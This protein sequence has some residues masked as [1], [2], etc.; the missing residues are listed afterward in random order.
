M[1]VA[2]FHDAR[3]KKYQKTVYTSGGLT[4]TYLQRYL[5]F[6]SK[7]T[8]C[9]REEVVK[10]EEEIKKLSICSGENIEFKGIKSLNLRSLFW[11][12]DRKKI[13]ENVKNHDFLIIRLP[14]FIGLVA[15]QEARKEKKK[16]VI[17]MVG[18]PFDSLWNYGKISKKIVAPIFAWINKYEIKKAKFVTYVSNEFL[19][20]RY[21]NKNKII[22]CSD[23]D[24]PTIEEK[25]LERRIKKIR[26]KQEKKEN[27]YKLG[28]IGSLN[29]NF[30][31]H[32]T[33]IKAI[34]QLKGKWNM[35]LHLLG[36]GD[37]KRWI[38]MAK[39]YE[40]EN[41]L[42]FDGVLPHEEVNKW[43]DE[44]DIYLIPSLTEGMPRALIEAMSRACPTIGTK[45]GGIPELL[46]PE[47]LINKKDEKQLREKIEKLITN[48][49]KME[50]MAKRNF[51]KSLEFQKEQ[52]DNKR[53]EFYDKMLRE[54]K[55]NE[56][57]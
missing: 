51:Y 27:V 14:S 47:M 55:L 56:C 46:D 31:G 37:Q 9:T 42:V 5:K 45:V 15:C 40:V 44:I 16:Y 53:N 25:N 50:E 23:V 38:A 57:E 48:S 2:F 28:M 11:G 13:Q 4:N 54:I 1:K 43:L 17:E 12:E 6:F 32:E 35:E 19:Q 36:T 52:L 33:A 24:I 49:E 26:E 21:P 18:C 7:V 34:S 10:T 39:K 20:K 3:L 8:L 41:Q 30:K 29:V 22:G